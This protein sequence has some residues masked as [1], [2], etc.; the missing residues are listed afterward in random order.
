MP[1]FMLSAHPK[2]VPAAL[3]LSSILVAGVKQKRRRLLVDGGCKVDLDWNSI[4]SLEVMLRI[5]RGF[6]FR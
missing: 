2:R 5:A 4:V 3:T 6:H 1:F